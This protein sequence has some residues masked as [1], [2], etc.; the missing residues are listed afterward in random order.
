MYDRSDDDWQTAP[1]IRWGTLTLGGNLVQVEWY[2][3][4]NV[5]Y[6]GVRQDMQMARLIGF[7]K[8]DWALPSTELLA[9]GLVHRCYCAY[10]NNQFGD[11]PKGI[12]Y[13]PFWSLLDWDFA[14]NDTPDA[15]YIPTVWLEDE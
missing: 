12:V 3:T 9:R 11:S 14:G 15:L 5:I 13:S 4:I 10:K 7:R 1:Q 6:N 8:T 2:E